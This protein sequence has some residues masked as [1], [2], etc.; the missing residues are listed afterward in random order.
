M[1]RVLDIGRTDKPVLSVLKSSKLLARAPIMN[2][3]KTN[4]FNNPTETAAIP[5][6]ERN[7]SQQPPNTTKH[8]AAEA[9]RLSS[10]I[11]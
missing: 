4:V 2:E 6:H 8:N 11:R 1:K 5:D 10:D 3:E 9:E 7:P